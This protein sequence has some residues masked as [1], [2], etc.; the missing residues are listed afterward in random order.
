MKKAVMYGA[1]NIGRGFIGQL[2]SQSGYETVFIDVNPVFIEALNTE[3][4]Y[5]VRIIS[6]EGYKEITIENV[7]GVNGTD[8]EAVADEIATADIMA[9]AVGANILKFIAKPVARGVEKRWQNGNETPLNIIIC[10]NLLDANHHLSRMVKENLPESLHQKFD[11]KVGLVEASIG[12]MVP[13]MT[14]E[15]QE[16]NPL[17]ICVEE[18]CELPVDKAA[19]KGEIPY[20]KNM[21]PFEPFDFYIRRKLFMHNMSHALT[22]YLGYMNDC[23]YI[24]EACGKPLIKLLALRALQES[25]TALSEEYGVPL[26]K[27]IGFSEDLIYRFGNKLLGDTVERVGKDP[28]RKL[29][30]YDRLIGAANLCVKKGISPVYVCLGLAAGYLYNNPNDAAAMEVQ[31]FIKQNGIEEAIVRYSNIEK[32]SSVFAY[33]IRFYEMFKSGESLE[34][35][36]ALAEK[37]KNVAYREEK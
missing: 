12:R 21:V 30:E 19:F 31:D 33:I 26:K 7:R 32:S 17:R 8:I 28:V 27:L 9:T 3:H 2:F 18:Y 35:V 22:A 6:D 29:S 24:W 37:L 4:K 5:P 11:E 1:G 10:E 36:A 16:G 23:G 20:L 34:K 14:P 25:A 15:M 13:V